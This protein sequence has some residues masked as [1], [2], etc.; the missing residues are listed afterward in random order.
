MCSRIRVHDARVRRV[1]EAEPCQ[2]RVGEP[3]AEFLMTVERALARFLGTRA[4]FSDIV[5]PAPPNAPPGG[6]PAQQS[7]E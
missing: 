1:R 7:Q 2:Q 6:P 4:G 5:Q 3:A